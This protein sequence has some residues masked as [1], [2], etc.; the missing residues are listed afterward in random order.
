MERWNKPRKRCNKDRKDAGTSKSWNKHLETKERMKEI[1]DKLMARK[2][3]K[4]FGDLV[5]RVS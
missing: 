5:E 3:F 4:G 2:G 1:D